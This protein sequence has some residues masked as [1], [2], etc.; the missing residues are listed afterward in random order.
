MNKISPTGT[1]ADLDANALEAKLA[2]AFGSRLAAKA[3]ELEE[4]LVNKFEG[5]LEKA[6]AELTDKHGA[7]LREGLAKAA[8][9]H[10]RSQEEE[11]GALE[12]RIARSA[13]K[14]VEG[15][16]EEFETDLRKQFEARLKSVASNGG[17]DLGSL[18]RSGLSR[19]GSGSDLGAADAD[20]RDRRVE[21]SVLKKVDAKLQESEEEIRRNIDA[22]V[23]KIAQQ[24]ELKMMSNTSKNLE[25]DLVGLK[26]FDPDDHKAS[27]LKTVLG[28]VE[29]R[30]ADL[31]DELKR[32]LDMKTGLLHQKVDAVGRDVA[33]S[34]RA[35]SVDGRSDAGG[36]DAT[37]SSM[38]N[39][40][41][42]M[43]DAKMD[44]LQQHL[45]Q[46]IDLRLRTIQDDLQDVAAEV[47]GS[48]LR[49]GTSVR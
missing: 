31:E 27:I 30:L 47:A 21:R 20:E 10:G 35:G 42:K 3:D 1:S 23:T 38:R 9:Q 25:S 6:K 33:R 12:Q 13:A 18:G 36:M 45:Q 11:M 49:K 34:V 8:E 14:K 28:R 43:V 5:K 48:P 44:D 24:T 19:G 22:A 17:N 29:Q 26:D 15:K 37:S 41:A 32:G 16:L 7:Q 40:T 46:V 2:K 4:D 39:D